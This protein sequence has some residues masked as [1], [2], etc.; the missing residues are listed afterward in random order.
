MPSPGRMIMSPTLAIG[1]NGFPTVTCQEPDG[2]PMSAC[3]A[4]VNLNLYKLNKFRVY[5]PITDPN[6]DMLPMSASFDKSAA[7]LL[8]F[9]G[10]GDAA[11]AVL[12]CGVVA[13]LY[14]FTKYDE[15]LLNIFSI[16]STML[17]LTTSLTKSG[18]DVPIF[19]NSVTLVD[20][21]MRIALA[22]MLCIATC[23]S[24]PLM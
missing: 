2:K 3:K 24:M 8:L 13:S 1:L 7:D 12:F 20:V 6:L 9:F 14:K 15:M 23:G 18:T 21:P 11:V 5:V 17:P 10:L 19:G 4:A 22:M 16:A